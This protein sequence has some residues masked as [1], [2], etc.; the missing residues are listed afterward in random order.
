[1]LVLVITHISEQEVEF[2]PAGKTRPATVKV[3]WLHL[4]LPETHQEL[5]AERGVAGVSMH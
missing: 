1:M 2:M 4:W 5:F 3:G